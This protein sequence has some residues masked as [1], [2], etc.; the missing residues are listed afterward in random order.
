MPV[1]IN[2]Q[3]VAEFTYLGSVSWVVSSLPKVSVLISFHFLQDPYNREC[4]S[5][6]SWL[7]VAHEFSGLIPVGF[8]ILLQS[9][10]AIS[11]RLGAFP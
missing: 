4:R 9:L 8:L 2:A 10:E 1:D 11:G 7:K 3:E 6:K 5:S